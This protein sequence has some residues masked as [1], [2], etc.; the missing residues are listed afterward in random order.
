M[1]FNI[2]FWKTQIL[3]FYVTQN[4]NNKIIIKTNSFVFCFL[5]TRFTS[6]SSH[7]KYFL[8]DGF[9]NDKSNNHEIIMMNISNNQQ[10]SSEVTA[11]LS[12]A[13]I[14]F[15][16]LR[17]SPTK[18]SNTLEQFVGKLPT[19]CLSVF[20]HY[21]RLALKGLIFAKGNRAEIAFCSISR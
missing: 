13:I 20:D 17:A 15:N 12:F 1:F 3:W 7:S 9:Y 6:L 14:I 4:N 21:V 19:N 2:F 5:F 8:R 16:P 18:W 11:L 10:K